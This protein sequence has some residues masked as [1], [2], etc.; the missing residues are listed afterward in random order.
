[1]LKIVFLVHKRVDMDA[2]EFRRH[3]RETQGAIGAKIPGVRKYVQNL[4]IAD[5]DGG[6]PPYDGFAEMW[7][8]NKE[9]FEQAMATPEAQAAIADLPNFL[10]VERMQSFVVDEINIV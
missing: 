5:P 3:W 9:A 4:T 8:D 10:D 2:Q 6:T 7:F 1:M